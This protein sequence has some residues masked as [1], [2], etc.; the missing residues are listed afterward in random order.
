MNK[1]VTVL[2]LVSL[3]GVAMHGFAMQTGNSTPGSTGQNPPTVVVQKQTEQSQPTAIVQ[4]EADQLPPMV[5]LRNGSE[6][7]RDLLA[8]LLP[9]M[10]FHC[11]DT[12][13]D[14]TNCQ[15]LHDLMRDYCQD[16]ETLNSQH[17]ELCSI[18][19]SSFRGHTDGHINYQS[20]RA[21]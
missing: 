10:H 14:D 16:P 21:F 1:L 2:L 3:T 9:F 19:Y 18:Y 13:K 4:K 15:I 7:K 5:E 12:E 6:V 11:K 8:E 17:R 20:P